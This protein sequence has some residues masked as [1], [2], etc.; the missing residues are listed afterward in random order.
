MA[1]PTIQD[2]AH[3]MGIS[4]ST[5]S[6]ALR[7]DPRISEKVIRA[8][9]STAVQLGYVPNI[10][11]SNLRKGKT[12]LIGLI[13]R[14]IRDGFCLEVIPSV[15]AACAAA[16]YGLLLCN[17]GASQQG[18]LEYLRTLLQRRVDGIILITPATTVPDPYLMFRREVPLVLID[19]VAN[20]API[21]TVSVD[22]TMGG[23]L[24]TRHLLELGHQ[25]IAFLSGPLS[26]SSS[27]R[28]V[29]GYRNAMTEAGISIENQIVV[30][31][32]KTDVQAGYD[33]MLD[34]IKQTPRPTAVATFSDLMAAG[35]LK[36]AR[37]SGIPVP[38]EL[39]IIGYDDIPLSSL[40]TPPLTTIKQNKDELGAIAVQLLLEEI[41]DQGHIHQQVQIPPTLILRGS[42]TYLKHISA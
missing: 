42:T 30:L 13:V 8:V 10:A 40:L 14:D 4:G 21:C 6:R 39:S 9:K 16:E 25:H 18:E 41:H 33:G 20:G 37:H 19:S 32:E 7:D 23:C 11:A 17:A 35:A 12:K 2:I 3:I 38:D 28:C 31:T 24:S 34:I 22:H 5:V 26:L 27:L 1:K 36:A 15:E 29:E